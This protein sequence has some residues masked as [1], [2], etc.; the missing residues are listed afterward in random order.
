MEEDREDDLVQT[1]IEEVSKMLPSS[2]AA[3]VANKNAN[4]EYVG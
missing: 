2:S 3:D 4:I 1:P